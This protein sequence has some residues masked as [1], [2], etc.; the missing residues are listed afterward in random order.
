MNEHTGFHE[1]RD[2]KRFNPDCLE[3]QW[4]E[5]I[6]RRDEAQAE[7]EAALVTIGLLLDMPKRVI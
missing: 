3:C 1:Y 7:L 5:M 4:E 2:G 6:K